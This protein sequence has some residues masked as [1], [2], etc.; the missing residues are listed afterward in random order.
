M[1]LLSRIARSVQSRQS[2]PDL[3]KLLVKGRGAG[4]CGSLQNLILKGYAL[5]VILLE[6]FLR[7]VQ[8]CE[9]LDVVDVTD[10]LAGV[11]IDY[12]PT[13]QLALALNGIRRTVL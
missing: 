6:P 11:D 7:G 9:H 2:Q 5:G 4:Q 1:R 10:L 13:S 12:R 8:I 3:P